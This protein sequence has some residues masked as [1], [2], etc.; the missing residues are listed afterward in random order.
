VRTTLQLDDD[1]YDLARTLAS[2]EGKSLGQVVSRLVRLGLAPRV[3]L[4]ERNG[5]PVFDVPTDSKPITPEMVRRAL[6]DG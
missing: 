5:F 2:V 6:E 1:V 4:H 3:S